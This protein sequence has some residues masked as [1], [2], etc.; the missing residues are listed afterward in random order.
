MTASETPLAISRP[1]WRSLWQEYRVYPDRIEIRSW[2]GTT[3]IPLEAV[4]SVEKRPALVVADAFRGKPLAYWCALKL[5]FADLFPHVAIHR[6]AGIFKNLR[7]TPE[8]P[9]AFVAACRNLVRAN[10]N[11][12][13]TA[14]GADVAGG[15]IQG[16]M[17]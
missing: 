6:R 13:A 11:P 9:D 16:G 2:V 8:D 12:P 17:P 15:C 3:V 5:D 1:T 7:I 10:D 14:A 4:V